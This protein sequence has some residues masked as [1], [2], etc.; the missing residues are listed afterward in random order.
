MNVSN[1]HAPHAS[2]SLHDLARKATHSP[3]LLTKEEVI[4]LAQ[5]VLKG[6]EHA[7]EEEKE[8]AKKATHNPEGVEAEQ[9]VKLGER[10]QDNK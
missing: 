2:D 1:D 3:K 8:I 4:R 10:A 5:H 6:G 9:I 7:T